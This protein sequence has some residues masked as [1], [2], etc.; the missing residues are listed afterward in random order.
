MIDFSSNILILGFLWLICLGAVLRSPYHSGKDTRRLI[1]QVETDSVRY[2]LFVVEDSEGVAREYMAEIFTPVCH[3]NKCYPVYINFFWDLLG[4]FDRFEM[5]E[6]ERLT[7]LDHIPFEE[8]DYD[9]LEAIL[10]NEN[11]ILGDYSITDLVVSTNTAESN[12]VDAVTGATSKTIQNEVISGAVY[13]CYTLWH[14]AHGNLSERTRAHTADQHTDET[15]IRFLESGHHPYQYWALEKIQ[16][17]GAENDPRFAVPLL[18]MIRGKNIFLATH[19]LE[20]LPTE[21]FQSQERQA[22]LWETFEQAPYR[23]QMRI[24]EKMIRLELGPKI[25]IQLLTQLEKSNPAQRKKLFEVLIN[26]PNMGKVQQEMIVTYLNKGLWEQELLAVLE[27]QNKPEK[28][29]KKALKNNR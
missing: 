3:T 28:E 16:E 4:N 25:H 5:P 6:G 11:S 18:Q 10:S 21:M 13:S 24:L 1:E 29:A 7:K 14:L 27:I 15:L 17:K 23:L 2:E 9:Q 8:E 20:E 12:G 22:W 19:L 26:Q